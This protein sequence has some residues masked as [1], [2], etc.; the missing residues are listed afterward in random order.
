[1]R[2]PAAQQEN[3]IE[4]FQRLALSQPQQLALRFLGDGEQVGALYSYAQID[5]GA[6]AVAGYLQAFVRP[7][8][9]VLLLF[10]GS[11]DYV[12]AF[13]GCL[14]AGVTAVPAYPPERLGGLRPQ[15]GERLS[16]IAA[17]CKPALVLTQ[18]DWIETVTAQ[19]G[20]LFASIHAKVV[21]FEDIGHAAAQS[22]RPPVLRGDS[23]AFLQYTSGSTSTPKGVMVGYDNLVAN[24]VAIQKRFEITAADSFVSWLP[25]FH[26]MGLVGGLM[27]PLYSGITLT[28][29]S[30]KH[31]LE[32]PVRWLEAI[33]RYGGSISGGPNFAYRLCVERIGE[34]AMDSLDLS[35]WRIAFCGAEPIRQETLAAFAEKFAAVG[36]N[37]NALYPCYG[38]AESTLLVTGGRPGS[39]AG[40]I[41]IN[42]DAMADGRFEPDAAGQP[43]VNCGAVQDG[44]T[45]A[46]MHPQSCESVNHDAIGEVWISGP[47]IAQGYWQNEAATA[48]GFV[49]MNG[50]SWLRTGDLAFLRDGEL[51]ITGRLKDLI[52]VRGQ[53]LYPQDIEILLEAQIEVLRK[54]R[55]AAFAVDHRDGEGIGIAAE[56]GRSTQKLVPPQALFDLINETLAQAYQE[57]ASVIL[58]LQP[59]TL[60][61][62]TSGKLQRRACW[63]GW[64]DG[65]LQPYAVYHP[66]HGPGP[67][68]PAVP[69]IAD[70]WSDTEQQV[71]TLFQEV[72]HVPAIE[73]SA[74]FFALG[75][76]SIDAMHL[77][78]LVRERFAIDLESSA[79]F[80]APAVTTFAARL[81][82]A[83]RKPDASPDTDLVRYSVVGNDFPLSYAQQRIWFHHQ[84]TPESTAYHMIGAVR[85]R[86]KLLRS[87]LEQTLFRLAQRHESLRT[88]FVE[89]AEMPR[90][91]ILAESVID[92]QWAA[93]DVI[94]RNTG[95]QQASTIATALRPFDL[96][97]G[98]LWRLLVIECG[99][100]T[101]ELYLV[102]HHIIADGWSVNV[103]LNELA[104]IYTAYTALTHGNLPELPELPV[105]YVDYAIWQR[106]R[107]DAG[108][109]A[110]QQAYWIEQLGKVQAPIHLPMDHPRPAM[111]N[112][113]GD[114]VRFALS[115]AASVHFR[116][117]MN[118]AGTTVFMGLLTA[119][120]ALLY[121]Y[122]GQTDVR[123]G[124]PVTNRNQMA[125]T[126]I[127]GL[128]VNM[129]VLRMPVKGMMRFD[130]LL[131]HIRTTALAAQ[132]HAEMPFDQLVE[133]LQPVRELGISPLFQVLYNHLQV[134]YAALEKSTGWKV[135]RIDWS[136]GGSQ[137]DLSLETEE[138]PDGTIRGV[139]V[140]AADLFDR[141][142]IERMA[143]HFQ[144]ILAHWLR[145]PAQYVST[146]QL[147]Q[148]DENTCSAG[149]ET[150]PF[151]PVFTRISQLALQQ[152][153]Q[154]A[155][156]DAQRQITYDEMERRSSR[157][158]Q[159]LA[160]LGAGAEHC[161]GLLAERGVD[162]VI[163]ALGILKAGAAYVPLDPD[164]PAERMQYILDDAQIGTVLLQKSLELPIDL[165]VTLNRIFLDEPNDL[166]DLDMPPTVTVTQQQLAYVIYTSG[167][168]GQP[169]GVGVAHG[170]LAMHCRAVAHTYGLQS[171]DCALHGA[172]FTFDAAVEQWLIPLLAGARL[173]IND[174][175]AW[176]V[177]EMAA[178]IR[179]HGVTL[180]Y[181]PTAPILQLADWAIEHAEKLPVRLCTVGGEAVARDAV[182]RIHRGLQ[183]QLLINGYGPTEAII[184]PLLWTAAAGTSCATPYAP[185]GQAVGDRTAYVLDSDLNIVPAGA[186]GELYIGGSGLARGYFQRPA[187]TAECFI[188]D[189]FGP[190]GSRMY[191]TRDLARRLASGDIEYLGRSD[192][193]IK[194]RGYRI[195]LG[196]IEAQLLALPG[197]REACATLQSGSASAR[198]VAYV[199][200]ASHDSGIAASAKHAL[201]QRLPGYMVPSVI[202]AVDH[203]PRT[204]HGK[205]DYAALPDAE[206][207]D[208]I[209]V[210]P[211]TGLERRLAD[212]W[213]ALLK[214]EDVGITDNFF[215]LGGDSIIA[216]QVVSRA[217][218]AGISFSPATLFRHQTIEKLAESIALSTGYQSVNALEP[219][220][221]EI[222]LT[223]I[224]ADF[225]VQNIPNRH[226][227]NQSLLLDLRQ[228][229]E[230]THLAAALAA[231]M[232]HHDALRLRYRQTA[233]GWSQRYI[234]RH[235]A[236]G[237]DI[238]WSREVSSQHE[239]E[240]CCAV[241]QESL[242]LE[243]GPLMR[244][245]HITHADKRQSL[246][247][248]IHH[249]VV[250]GVSWRILLEDLEHTYQ[251]L[252]AGASPQLPVV[253]QSF[254][255]H[256][257]ALHDTAQ[258]RALAAEV[259]YWHA[260][261]ADA[262]PGFP[263]DVPDAATS[264]RDAAE[265]ALRIDS[266]HTRAL[267]EEACR[268]YRTRVD[269]LLLAALVRT[270]AVYRGAEA[271]IVEV[272]SHGRSPVAEQ[273]GDIDLS[274][275]VGWFTAVYPV[276]LMFSDDLGRCIRHAKEALRSVPHE[277]LGYGLLR[278]CAPSALREQANAWPR[279]TVTLNYLG[280]LDSSLGTEGSLFGWN[281]ES[282]GQDR[283]ADAPLINALEINAYV[284]NGGLVLNWRY[285][286]AQYR[287]DTM[288]LLIAAYHVSLEEIITHCLGQETGGATPS[289]FP[290]VQMRQEDLDALGPSIRQIEDIYPLTALQ[291]GILYHALET[292]ESDAY[293]YQRGF[294]LRGALSVPHFQRAWEVVANRHAA[295]RSDYRWEGLNTPVQIVCKSAT[296]RIIEADWCGLDES[297]QWYRFDGLLLQERQ[298]GFDFGAASNLRLRLI[299][300][301]QD[302]WWFVWSQHH[303]VL[304]GWSMGIV[305]RDVMQ[306]YHAYQHGQPWHRA[307][308][309]VYSD[310]LHW[311]AKR[312]QAQALDY[313]QQ[314]LAGFDTPT[315]LPGGRLQGAPGYAELSCSLDAVTTRRI[316]EAAQNNGV[317]LNTLVQ[318]AWA[319]M[320]GRYSGQ[321]GTGDIVFGI[322]VS[323]RSATIQGIEEWVGLLIN[324]V[325]LRVRIPGNETVTAWLQRLQ[326]QN[327]ELQ[328]YEDT[329][330]ND[331]QRVSVGRD[332]SGTG[333]GSGPGLFETI[334]VFENYPL[335]EALLK[336]SDGLTM[337]LL[338][339]HRPHAK[340]EQPGR[341]NF[342]LSVIASLH[343][344]RLTLDFSWRCDR[345][346]GNVIRA[347]AE[348]MPPLIEQLAKQLASGAPLR[349]GDISLGIESEQGQGQGKF[350]GEP[351]V[352]EPLPVLAAWSRWVAER[353]DDI[354]IQ[355]EDRR[356]SYAALDQ[357]ANRLARMLLNHGVTADDR[358]GLYLADRSA[359]WVL[360][361]LAV[362]KAG[363]VYLPLTQD[364]SEA[365]VCQL[366]NDA[367][368]RRVITDRQNVAASLQTGFTM[369]HLDDPQ[370][371]HCAADAVIPSVSPDHLA[372]VIYTSGSTGRPKGV[373]VSHRALSH[374]V[375]GVLKRLALSGSGS[376][377][378]ISTPMA[379]LGNTVLFGALVSGSLLHL[380]SAE[381]AAD[382]AAL[383]SYMQEHN[384]AVL[385]IVPGHL[386]GLLDAVQDGSVLP[387]EMLV[388]GGEAADP[389]LI[390][391]VRALLPQCRIVNHYGPAETCVG[392]LT[393]E[394][395]SELVH[396]VGDIVPIGQPLPGV[397]AYVLD[398]ELNPLPAGI[399]GELYLGGAGL[400]RGYHGNPAA[401]AERFVPDPFGS[402]ERLY[403]SG[404]RVMHREGRIEFIGRSDDQI[405]L[406]GYRIEPGEIARQLQTLPGVRD[407][408]VVPQVT[409]DGLVTQ[410]LGYYVPEDAEQYSADAVQA[411]LAARLPEYMLPALIVLDAIPR[412]RNGKIDRQALPLPGKV[413]ENIYRAPRNALEQLLCDIW[414]E[415]LGMDAV[416]IDDHFMALGGDSILSLQVIARVRRQGIKL[417]PRLMFEY[418]TIEQLAGQLS[419]SS[420]SSTVQDKPV[421]AMQDRGDSIIRNDGMTRGPLS[422]AQKR[423]WFLS[424]LAP[425]STAYHI[426]GGLKFTGDF[427]G[428]ALNSALS[429]LVARHESLRTSLH[430]AAGE[431]YQVIHPAYALAADVIDLSGLHDPAVT[432]SRLD[433]V[434]VQDAQRPFD[435]KQGR[436]LRATLVKCAAGE[437]VL[438]MSFHHAVVDGW[439]MNRF[440]AEFAE[441][442]SAVIEHRAPVL[443]PLPIRYID[444]VDWQQHYLAGAEGEKHL[445]YW[446]AQ[447]SGDSSDISSPLALPADRPRLAADS[448]HGAVYAFELDVELAGQLR[449][450]AQ[451]ER[452]T[453]FIVMLTAFQT[454]LYR[455]TGQPVL[456]I[457]IPVANRDRPETQGIVGLFV[458]TLVHRA[459][460]RGDLTIQSLLAA[461]QQTVMDAQTHQNLP[462]ERLVEAL[463]PERHL[464]HNP[465]FQ[466]L[467][468]H[469]K[470]DF[471]P[472]KQLPGLVI[473]RYPRAAANTQFELALHTEEDETGRIKGTWAYAM[474]RFDAG[475]IARWHGYFIALLRQL[476]SN[477]ARCV[478]DLDVMN[479]AE[480]QRLADCCGAV[481][482]EETEFEAVHS[483]VSRWA[484][485]EPERVAVELGAAQLSYGELE[486]WSNRV[487]HRLRRLGVGTDT[488][489]GVY[490]ER[491]LELIVG[492]LGILKA[493]GA[494][495]AL[496]PAHPV[497]RLRLMAENAKLGI[498][499]TTADL[500]ARIRLPEHITALCLDQDHCE[501]EINSTPAGEI[502]PEQLA[503]VLYT[504]GSTGQP[505]AAGNTHRGL[506]NRLSWM[507]AAYALT[508][509]EGVLQKTPIGFDVSVWELL[510]PLRVGARMV[511]AAPGAHRDPAE[512]VR[513][514]HAHQITTLHFVPSMLQEF[515][516]ADGM[517]TCQQ[518][519]QIVC[520][521]EALGG[522][523]ASTLFMRLPQVA[524][525]NLYGPTECAIDVT[526]WTCDRAA[527]LRRT[528]PIGRPIAQTVIRILDRDLNPVPEGVTGELYLGG[529]GVGRGY[530]GQGA[531]T[532]ERFVPDPYGHPGDRLYRSGDLGC[533]REGVIE[534][535]G[536]VDEQIKLRGQ[537]I[538]LGEITS[539]LLRQPG[540]REAAVLVREERIVAYVTGVTRDQL[541][542][543]VLRKGLRDHLPEAM[544]PAKLILLEHLPKTVNGKLDRKALP[545]PEWTGTDKSSPETEWERKLAQL[546]QEILGVKQIGQIGREDSFFDLGGHSLLAM[547]LVARLRDEWQ[548]NVSVR[549]IFEQPR[550]CQLAA[551]IALIHS[552]THTAENNLDTIDALLREMESS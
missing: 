253:T 465:L 288:K 234:P 142:T 132:D 280:R 287:E 6:Q 496:E 231:L 531:L 2:A 376:M 140:Y 296:A 189:P 551:E 508:P 372:Y 458:N 64:Q 377:A 51:F 392:V 388:L 47:S 523:L 269:E 293:F 333:I 450:W 322:T 247:L 110:S 42:A 238:L 426:L 545:A 148:A 332:G 488:L 349:L 295:L 413:S 363:A 52:L 325:P 315:P 311:L 510:W 345:V 330:L 256:A 86:G 380:I 197:V 207:E 410:L 511:L 161:V 343:Q 547:R 38:L 423:L 399:P 113:R 136:G 323:G 429:V 509:G 227:W 470:R 284:Y 324:T 341:N 4:R 540:V 479:D 411:E 409:E 208:K 173:L 251:Q 224:Q 407:C 464:D 147:E 317:T 76:N 275:T 176:G 239:L 60:P 418:P 156:I 95:R 535:A 519:R 14:Y 385:K 434:A 344:E 150:E 172:R 473:D 420:E 367:G 406:R 299:R 428:D 525:H 179:T 100:D 164:Y 308:A 160:R 109:L 457:G 312:D 362:F 389:A 123:I 84:I 263:P 146:V 359:E 416:G 94:D 9:R 151:M 360:S 472:L 242:D 218:N 273:S 168:T 383:G 133:A 398:A 338:E 194:L 444:Y 437:C 289:D 13:L 144:T 248:V 528:I 54:G 246:L 213:Q 498:I 36:L 87:V 467:Y 182:E 22:W 244:A 310:Y 58:L 532:A 459:E 112:G 103:L 78:A 527:D 357:A 249:L 124:V 478:A 484:N 301:A 400:A 59:G 351:H 145:D 408:V 192:R 138:D 83:R 285:S 303:I 46:L 542:V 32:R 482:E 549:L 196:E 499:L 21:A 415:V 127:I 530:W 369:I 266:Q 370:I 219:E 507:Q 33:T 215:E 272:E 412:T 204:A 75:G 378:M 233:E 167:S 277:G 15:H 336:H 201:E 267:L 401:T 552:A 446:M 1:M 356:W 342:P 350:C 152:P 417:T 314:Q 130:E 188:P 177:E 29:M 254:R 209:R 143:G 475:T 305:L 469:Q 217:R 483:G 294:L 339:E 16:V 347:I 374:Y 497:E 432:A 106:N 222:P 250:D 111:P 57:P 463:Q 453:L 302:A 517:A 43:V 245:V 454:L 216:L 185:I 543:E 96:A 50:K 24:E 522:E 202:I 366:L 487:A 107:I 45:L 492:I 68:A 286:R 538:E 306:A 348:Y 71:A 397:R 501:D 468:N 534:Y 228:P 515:L 297:E 449:A 516:T 335:D 61:K 27:Q 102:M 281:E 157:I 203:L 436:P 225:F 101:Y 187:L 174:P 230:I 90:Q 40:V 212:I 88:V 178:A 139:F 117:R 309:Y 512:L 375:D 65:T 548:V 274:R 452:T 462:F 11:P 72:L 384:V 159:Q 154:V 119:F 162:W 320:L 18:R 170:P 354:A 129:L 393:H 481:D 241:A 80:E 55:I 529:W 355:Y 108:A 180:I 128:F 171:T 105:R 137:F 236:A 206:P 550:L 495:V 98:P 533:W 379:D 421:A 278:H 214:I 125:T 283:D 521:G 69:V 425:E 237:Q 422:P 93:D 430:E 331:I 471:A 104:G 63:L 91:L 23:I 440:M 260:V 518:L 235:T 480:W 414:R 365:R 265:I 19:M 17:D 394:L 155:L 300:V 506:S 447:L 79:I 396:D 195:E 49:S 118:A 53:N 5:A 485:K 70:Q 460:L 211:R 504:S 352:H 122:S 438:L 223:P 229:I 403:R 259:D 476:A 361:I 503:Y 270:A 329:P 405:K 292:P 67:A 316:Q 85:I 74:S 319:L 131:Q 276:R 181:P 257:Q 97:K 435:L 25:L 390:R 252:A 395:A 455:L 494:Y 386:R 153:G 368:V 493:G 451:T 193:Q 141:A 514:I 387:G 210:M 28:L 184:T 500:N 391:R 490:M 486:R 44:H 358:I 10:P 461:V 92:L 340:D 26:D 116:E 334:L 282:S 62:T 491:S 364:L 121:R 279:P 30:P 31:F 427:H 546:W 326:R 82:S 166:N 135:E 298:Q 149:S 48:A 89:S 431:L 183:P 20:T 321:S 163:A 536:R 442:Y 191:R 539:Q 186:D 35:T 441:C 445:A 39:G 115:P 41:N 524:L 175:G 544:V 190:P 304:D 371:A 268:T 505:K 261:T 226:H 220:D 243:H 520:S 313:W 198:L 448:Y 477:T 221:G 502:Y 381:R 466:V 3:I 290:L 353:P 537:R 66:D 134:D 382:P 77:L 424:Q 271:M 262:M 327:F 337:G 158:A 456:P 404:D 402:G 81:D 258:H 307:A 443:P 165:S 205:V 34:S 8:D 255:Q 120:A 433:E 169:K 199:A 200:T 439:S 513:L 328:A 114:V 99:H 474:E 318:G 126:G 526:H 56:I 541:D 489:I 232:T 7:G 37:A 291:Q 240:Q 346:D 264:M 73:R 12:I 419:A 373:A